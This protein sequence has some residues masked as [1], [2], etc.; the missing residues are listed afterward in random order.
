MQ[1][2]TS[3]A[4]DLVDEVIVNFPLFQTGDLAETTPDTS[5]TVTSHDPDP[6]EAGRQ[7]GG[8]PE[9]SQ[10]PLTQSLVRQNSLAAGRQSH[11]SGLVLYL[12]SRQSPPRSSNTMSQ[13]LCIKG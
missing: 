12:Y 9:L 7:V 11:D 1:N 5:Q 4:V 6:R 13:R 3:I 10:E 8:L 2:L